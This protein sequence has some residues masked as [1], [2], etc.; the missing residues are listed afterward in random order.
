MSVVSVGCVHYQP[1]PITAEA[2]LED[3]QARRLDAPDISEFLVDR[4]GVDTWP[5]PVWDLGTL[6]LAAL[7]Y[8][9]DLDVA[10][11]RWGVIEAG[12]ITAGARPDPSLAASI[13][14]DSTSKM[15]RPWIPEVVLSLPVETAGKR[16]LRVSRARALSQAAQL[17]VLQTAW[18]VRGRLS[19]AF[20]DLFQAQEM[21]AEL[22]RL[23]EVQLQSVALLEAQLDAGAISANE[24]SQARIDAGRT[25]LAALEAAHKR[26]RARVDLASAVGVPSAAFEG[27]EISFDG[28]D[29][30][31]TEPPTDEIRRQ[32]LVHRADI[33]SGL[34]AYEAAQNTLQLE[35]AK[36]YP[37]LDIGAGYQLDQVVNKW[38]L[39][40]N[41]ILPIF[42]RNKG[43][44][45]EAEAARTAAAAQFLALQSRV[46]AEVDGAA[47]S[48]RSAVETVAEAEA[49]LGRLEQREAS[50]RKAYGLGAISKLEVLGAGIEVA[51]GRLA[52]IESLASAQQ[53]AGELE[54]AVQNP[55][56]MTDWYL[57]TPIR[58]AGTAEAHDEE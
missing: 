48:Y 14:Y 10:R 34:A 21:E 40:L 18:A 19:R 20:V 45:A 1:Q 53:A 7:Y 15:I 33:L 46:L 27:I 44:I 36:Q 38:T 5:P 11:A 4:V 32:A 8:S 54:N 25:R 12:T 17:D 49:M 23:H 30:L 47:V 3:F 41:V 58:A 9:P 13:G 28:L 16:G 24:L 50:I 37:D 31:T 2:T 42:N 43:P 29:H 22:A 51:A 6:T 57:V 56:D 52:R 39:G 55:L 26:R 35:I